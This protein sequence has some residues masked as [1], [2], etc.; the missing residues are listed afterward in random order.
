MGIRSVNDWH[1]EKQIKG[2]CTCNSYIG[3]QVDYPNRLVV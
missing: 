3:M 2:L 1:R